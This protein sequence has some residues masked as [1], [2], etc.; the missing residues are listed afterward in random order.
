MTRNSS[1]NQQDE[2]TT[3]MEQKTISLSKSTYRFLIP[4]LAKVKEVSMNDKKHVNNDKKV[5]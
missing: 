1:N 2:K 3:K 4:F 5:M